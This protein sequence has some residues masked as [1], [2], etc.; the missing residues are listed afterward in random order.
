MARKEST[1]RLVESA[2]AQAVARPIERTRSLVSPGKR[3]SAS[4]TPAIQERHVPA[5]EELSRQGLL[6]RSGSDPAKDPLLF[7]EGRNAQEFPAS[8]FRKMAAG[9]ITVFQG[10]PRVSYIFRTS[11]PKKIARRDHHRKEFLYSADS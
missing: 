11:H 10:G 1:L 8:V 2:T 7:G 3:Q 9:F 5:G 6:S 4:T